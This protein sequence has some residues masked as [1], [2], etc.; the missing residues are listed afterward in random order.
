MAATGRS[1]QRYVLPALVVSGAGH[2]I[3]NLADFP[4]TILL[5]LETLVPL[6]VTVLLGVA[7]VYRP[8]R[9]TYA[10][11]GI[12]AL[13]VIIGGGMTVIPF[14]FL[15][16]VPEQ[17]IRHYIVHVIYIV[18]QLPLFWVGIRGF[19]KARIRT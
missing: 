14:G 6:T 9:S 2:V 10:A 16:F 1:T 12:W 18:T 15:P 19:R 11:L 13:V 7:I 3:H 4:V 5:G 17:S 8:G